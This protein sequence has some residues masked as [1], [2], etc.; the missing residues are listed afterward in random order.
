MPNWTQE[1]LTAI[2]L[3]DQ[4]VL[5]SAAAGS[6][7][8]AV[9]TER[10][11]RMLTDEEHPL[12]LDRLLA[13]TFTRAAAAELKE[14]IGTSLA[15]QVEEHPEHVRLARALRSLPL[16]KI[17]TID[18][19]CGDLVHRF[20]SHVGV[21][22]G[23]RVADPQENDLTRISL[24]ENLIDDAYAGCVPGLSADTFSAFVTR[25]FAL[26]EMDSLNE[27]LLFLIDKL[28][29]LENGIETLAEDV[30]LYETAAASPVIKTPWGKLLS[31]ICRDLAVHDLTH[32]QNTLNAEPLSAEA[33][34]RF[35]DM[36]SSHRA[37]M[38]TL[39]SGTA[40]YSELKQA[41]TCPLSS[42]RDT[43][44]A[45][46]PADVRACLTRFRGDHRKKLLPYFH[47][48][49]EEWATLFKNLAHHSQCL[50]LL[51]REFSERE[52]AES[53]RRGVYSF[54]QIER[55][56]YTLLVQNGK[57]TAIAEDL[58]KELDAVSVDEYQDVSPIQHAIFE[59]IAPERGRF[60]VGD[61]K[62][63]IYRFRHADPS[64]FAALRRSFPL[65]DNAQDSPNVSLFMSRNFRCD[66]PVVNYVNH[67][68]DTLFG[69][70]GD[71]IGY[72]DADRLVLGK[73][74]AD[75]PYT[76]L[77]EFAVFY[78]KKSGIAPVSD[79]ATLSDGMPDA[80]HVAGGEENP[81]PED[82][83][84]DSIAE[85]EAEEEDTHREAMWVASRIL[86]L[87]NND[88]LHDGV[89]PIRASDIAILL[90][91]KQK[92]VLPYLAAL[93]KF[94]IPADTP[95][96]TDFFT[97]PEVLLAL[98]LLRTVDN[99]RRDIPLTA[100][101]L[102]PLYRLTPDD[103][104]MVRRASPDG[105]PL[106]DALVA[107]CEAHPEFALGTAFL[108]QLAAF[109][110]VAEDISVDRL[111]YRLM[112]ETPLL[113]IAG[114][115]GKGGE[116]NLRLFYH[117]ALRYSSGNEGLY[118]FIHYIDRQI[119]TGKTFTPPAGAP[120]EAR[121]VTVMTIH[122]SKGL[123]FPVV[124]L[125]DCGKAF[126]TRDAEAH[127]VFDG[128]LPVA[129]RLRDKSG[130]VKHANPVHNLVCHS[131]LQQN[132]E[133]EM[134]LLYVALTRARERLFVSGTISGVRNADTYLTAA[135]DCAAHPTRYGIL[136]CDG[137]LPLLLIAAYR[138]PEGVNFLLDPE[139]A[140]PE[141]T[142]HAAGKSY[143]SDP[144]AVAR[145]MAE[146]RRRFEFVYP[147]A[148]LSLLPGKLSV[149]RLSP[150]LLDG[151][152]EE[153]THLTSPLDPIDADAGPEKYR[154]MP[155]A[156]AGV[157][158]PD[159]TE[160]GIVSHQF[161]Q[162]CDF[163]ALY[164]DGV[165]KEL[166]RLVEHRFLSQK[167]AALVRPEELEK[168][169]FSRLL[170][171]MR[172]AKEVK[173]EFRFHVRLPAAKFTTDPSL[174]AL[175]EGEEL[176][177]QGVMD[178]LLFAPDGSITLVDYKTDRLTREE[179]KNPRLAEEKLKGRHLPQL[180]YYAAAVEHIFGKKPAHVL[181]YSLHLGDSIELNLDE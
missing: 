35:A 102:S 50:L 86:S 104:V 64:I 26:R 168:F 133:E 16:A 115:D 157:R 135:K 140:L 69:V 150:T 163:G 179:L 116:N 48:T 91:S 120:A 101:L 60:L 40:T 143:V 165:Q 42:Q 148:H 114:A 2:T 139:V 72:T 68:F 151:T 61:I 170:A 44:A 177:V 122:S 22:D 128:T 36:L 70:V 113:A 110:D 88:T 6:G 29:T 32:L 117:Y 142:V 38:E 137:Y 167:D 138:H 11:I 98:S 18:S 30:A 112:T 130:L 87:L 77:P 154:R 3:R 46:L 119:E 108:T 153:V 121:G 156:F 63:S 126:S 147:H 56:A 172:H 99:P 74:Q 75:A 21:S 33:S 127:F 52:A 25:L 80:A 73:N 59:A 105:I 23:Y 132:T 107:Y 181:L 37:A 85:A 10:I 5:L 57:R 92:K 55:L 49:S 145:L 39:A 176:L 51:A 146:Y 20:S 78:G 12:E 103:L 41:V 93:A 24:M 175:L 43:K 4:T 158:P 111:F 71:S 124:F 7:K 149:S 152:E 66:A 84:K 131:L 79:G 173:R 129:Y 90:R 136:Q 109:R 58:A 28:E 125:A 118:N 123:E 65:P 162:F 134:R 141:T 47:Y 174:A 178:A 53:H 94:G 14:R 160:R 155:E 106:Y 89:S 180:R 95:E 54:A 1:Q 13:V 83:T 82:D 100:V 96:T 31:D 8:T 166:A 97:C 144:A 9:L 15:K 159:P 169:R 62:Q 45:Q 67:V 171:D 81:L 19:F 17:C 161:M 164:E 27:T 76:P 34:A